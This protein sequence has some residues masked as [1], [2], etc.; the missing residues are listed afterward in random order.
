[1]QMFPDLELKSRRKALP[2][3]LLLGTLIFL[4]ALLGCGGDNS[5]K[6]EYV[7]V[8]V[9]EAS[10]RDR[11]STVYN[12]SGLVHNGERLVVLE[13]MQNR[14]FV[15]VRTP[16]GEEGW[17]HERYLADQQTF[18]QF[19]RLTEEFKS[20][21][22]QSTATT[23]DQ[24]KVHVEPGRKT[25]YLYLL[26]EKDKVEL[27]KRRTVPRNEPV[28]PARESKD[29]DKDS[30]SDE[31]QDKP[32]QPVILEDWW[33]VRD[34]QKRV[35]WVYGRTLYL[36]APDEIAQYAEGQRI[37]AVFKLDEVPDKD[38]KVPEYLVLL[39]EPRDGMPFDFN[40]VRVFTWNLRKHRYETAY[41]ERNLEG[42]LPVTLGQQDFGKEGNLRTFTLHLKDAG[43][44]DRQQVYKFN[45]PI[46][47]KYFAAGEAHPPKAKKKRAE[48][49]P[50]L[51]H[52]QA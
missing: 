46:V 18:D 8:A 41:R 24:V 50:R 20:A 25:G 40:Q 15:R 11:V 4:A 31:D 29:K 6:S 39:T 32:G 52:A 19:A 33:L 3:Y 30:D 10:L 45:P 36:D 13:H 26:G 38:K 35:G 27:L 12:K 43:G 7:Y 16:R 5:E 28:T 17:I 37:V 9:P 42:F 44:N 2:V 23:S 49:T 51:G 34:I 1:M 21:P 14:R 22:A 48:A 47:R